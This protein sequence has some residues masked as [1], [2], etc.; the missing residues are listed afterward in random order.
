MQV[1]IWILICRSQSETGNLVHMA[2]SQLADANISLHL[3]IELT[4]EPV[5]WGK[6]C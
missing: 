2:A 6:S 4:F 1:V 5:T 3:I